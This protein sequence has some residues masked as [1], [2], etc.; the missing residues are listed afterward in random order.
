[1]ASDDAYDAVLAE[2]KSLYEAWRIHREVVNRA[3][4]L[5]N[6]EV[7]SFTD[8]LDKDDKARTE[9]QAQLD[10]KL[11]TITHGQEMIKR[12]QWVRLGVEVLAILLVAAYLYGLSR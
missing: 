5:L 6:K 4:G 8:R 2:L 11:E 10:Q 9:R 12:W 7:I 3:I 1:M